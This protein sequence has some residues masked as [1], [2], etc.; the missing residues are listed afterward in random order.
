M[1][2][3][4]TSTAIGGLLAA[5]AMAQ[6]PHYT[7]TDLGALGATGQPYFITRNGLIAGTVNQPDGTEHAVLWYKGLKLDIGAPGLGGKNSVAYGANE[8]GQFVGQAQ[9]SNF[10]PYVEDFCGFRALGLPF[11]PTTCRPFLWMNGAM[12]A[13]PT[14]G[15]E[16]GA[17]NQINSRGEVVG[18]AENN[19]RDPGCP[20]PQQF[21]FRPVI[22]ERAGIRELPIVPGDLEGT[23]FAI[24]D[25]GEAVGASGQ[26]SLFNPNLLIYLQPLHALFWQAGTMTDLGTLGGTGQG[27]GIVALNLN[28]QGQVVGYS[29]VKGDRNFHAFVW[30]KAAG[31][32]DLG[33]LPGDV[34]S[35]AFSINDAG[36]IVGVSLDEDFNLRAF[37]RQNGQMTDLTSLIPASSGMQL[38]LPCSI[39]SRGQIIGLAIQKSTGTL[40]GFLL[41]PG[42][43][44]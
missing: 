4:V 20:A 21:Q 33:T 18:L 19:I 39:N 16:N 1:K 43:A 37:L 8:R 40:H 42:G 14:L 30:T 13:L 9:T 31:M 28:N 41:T 24:N 36:N 15:G 6:T 23:A 34:N 3:I 35:S 38:V 27:N 32:Q 7:I 44:E 11:V 17:A 26:C 2:S 29:D 5:L 10:D 22:W 25:N 12:M